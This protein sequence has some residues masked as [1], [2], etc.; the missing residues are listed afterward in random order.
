[1]T[2]PTV[3]PELKETQELEDAIAHTIKLVV[4]NAPDFNKIIRAAMTDTH[5]QE[6]WIKAVDKC[7]SIP[8]EVGKMTLAKAVKLVVYGVKSYIEA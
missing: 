1:M 6:L 4:E 5:F 7:T 2:E 3:D 8:S